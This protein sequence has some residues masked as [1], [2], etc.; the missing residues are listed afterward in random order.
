MTVFVSRK[1]LAIY[2]WT[3]VAVVTLGLVTSAAHAVATPDKDSTE[4]SAYGWVGVVLAVVGS[5]CTS[6][7]YV[8]EDHIFKT[9]SASP[10]LALACES[11][12]GM[13]GSLLLLLIFEMTGVEKTSETLYQFSRSSTLVAD[14]AVYGLCAGMAAVTGLVFSK[15]LS[16]V[17]RTVLNVQRTIG[18]WGTEL[19]LGWTDF[20]Y[21]NFVAVCLLV[22]GSFLFA[23][24]FSLP[25]S[26]WSAPV[27]CGRFTDNDESDSTIDWCVESPVDMSPASTATLTRRAADTEPCSFVL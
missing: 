7:R 26:W 15:A 25:F 6:I 20:D 8:I 19:V 14:S 23:N 22:V 12:I 17:F 27:R 18:T 24:V 4:L 1:P 13:V 5:L 16:A 3:G 11:A 10:F 21:L 9:H 2:G